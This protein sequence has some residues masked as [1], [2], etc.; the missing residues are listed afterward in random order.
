MADFTPFGEI[1]LHWCP[2]SEKGYV[3][4]TTLGV[5][6]RWLLHLRCSRS[7]KTPAYKTIFSKAIRK[8]GA[9][10]F[11][12]HS[13]SV[14]GSQEQLDN[15]EK[16]WII[17]LQT[18][19]PNG[20]NLADGGYAAAGHVVSA[21]VRARLSAAAKEQWKNPE[22]R[23][24]YVGHKHSDETRQ[25]MSIAASLRTVN[26]Q[27]PEGI[28]KRAAKLRGLKR[29]P[30]FCAA[31]SSRM[32][33]RQFSQETKDKMSASQKARWEMYHGS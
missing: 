14:A 20:Y 23:A 5:V 33:G 22:Y 30:E 27:T 8:Y 31:Q 6:R 11:E 19:A 29:T 16:V 10:A 2:A 1:Y 12:H 15:L 26:T 21:E 28:E 24:K 9:S 32:T 4:Q 25:K 17:L 13:L 18:K 3:G 7:A